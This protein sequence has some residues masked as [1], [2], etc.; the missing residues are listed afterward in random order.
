MLIKI[1][2]VNPEERQLNKVIDILQDGGVVVLP[3]DGV[4][5]FTCLLSKN[6]AIEKVA[7]LKGKKLE[8]ADLS[9]L[10]DD[11]S[12]LAEYTRQ[13]DTWV[14]KLMKRNLPGPF[15]FILNANNEVPKIF[16]NNKKTIG[17]RIPDNA[18]CSELIKRIGLPLVSASVHH[19]DEIVEY[20]T[21]PELIDERWGNAVDAVI[22]GGIGGLIPSTVVDC[23]GSE[24]LLIRE[25]S[26]ELEY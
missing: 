25:G 14:Y 8:K 4:Y 11:L 7:Q 10:F 13:V 9:F 3:T 17:I 18:I 19:D 1:H 15:T 2:P 21:D 22:D 23:T 6:K 20:I 24:P 5:A 12:H 16:K 26:V